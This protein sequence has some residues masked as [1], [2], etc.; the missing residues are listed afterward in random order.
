MGG[1]KL[2]LVTHSLL[3]VPIGVASLGTIRMSNLHEVPLFIIL[4]MGMEAIPCERF[5]NLPLKIVFKYKEASVARLNACEL[6][7]II[8]SSDLTTH[9]KSIEIALI[10]FPSF[11]VGPLASHSFDGKLFY[12]KGTLIPVGAIKGINRLGTILR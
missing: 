2:F 6:P 11:K 5:H 12:L 7:V 8:L 1:V 4:V 3:A 9:S 10:V